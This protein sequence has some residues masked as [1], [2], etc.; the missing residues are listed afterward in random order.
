M[1]AVAVAVVIIVV[2]T[3]LGVSVGLFAWYYIKKRRE[4]IKVINEN[5]TD[6][7]NFEEKE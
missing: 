6:V 3:V 4:L 5:K 7:E 2:V 1:S